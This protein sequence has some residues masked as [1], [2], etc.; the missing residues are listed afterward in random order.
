MK[1]A[2]VTGGSR[3]IGRGVSLA[4]SRLGYRICVTGRS[5]EN[6]ETLRTLIEGNG[7]QC[8]YFVCDHNNVQ[9]TIECFEHIGKEYSPDLV[10]NNAWGGYEQMVQDGTYTWEAKFWDQPMFR[11]TSMVD[12]GVRTAFICSKHCVRSMLERKAGAI[13]NISFWAARHYMQN[14]IYGVSKAAIDKMSSDMAEE[15]KEYS[16]PAISLY[17]GLV[18]TEAVMANASHF[19]MSNS[20][21]PEFVGLVADAFFRDGDN[22]T[23]TGGYFTTAELAE[24]YGILDE[25]GKKIKPR[26]Y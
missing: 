14:I 26:R 19:D 4:L 17:P 23:K 24:Q 22:M 5:K 25:D 8:R 13:V 16:I 12:V 3:G 7:S 18:R 10:V 9:S 20:E 11:W 15:L 1:T 2:V 6:L 21:S